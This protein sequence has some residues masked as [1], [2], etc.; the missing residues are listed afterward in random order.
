M[1]ILSLSADTVPERVFS[2]PSTSGE[3]TAVAMET[4]TDNRGLAPGAAL[5]SVFSQSE[6]KQ[7]HEE[8]R[9]CLAAMGQDEILQEQRKLLESL[10]N[11]FDFLAH[12]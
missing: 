4:E 11:Y 2:Q 10:G 6:A 9:A 5:K 7:I 12:L 1:Y 3:M 8:N